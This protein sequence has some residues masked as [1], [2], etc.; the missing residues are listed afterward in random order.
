MQLAALT[1]HHSGTPSSCVSLRAYR[2][3][4]CYALYLSS[5]PQLLTHFLEVNVHNA[6]AVALINQP[7]DLVSLQQIPRDHISANLSEG[8]ENEEQVR[9]HQITIRKEKLRCYLMLDQLKQ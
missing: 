7:V 8:H 2:A 9:L 1:Q 3:D 5:Y 6:D 4:S